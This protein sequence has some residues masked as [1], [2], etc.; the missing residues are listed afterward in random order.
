VSPPPPVRPVDV[1]A[2]GG[3]IAMRGEHAQPALDAEALVAA[4]PGLAAV[5]G[6]RARTV[7]NV[8]GPHLTPAMALEVALAA[9]DAAR[10]G[11]GVVVTHGTDTLEETAL[12]CDLVADAQ[13][14]I[15][16]TGA[17]RPASAPGADG[18]ANL[19]DAVAAAGAA[20]TTG[21]GAL[22]CF[23]GEL[24]A[25]RFARKVDS[26]GPAAFASPRSGPVGRVAE[27]RAALWALPVRGP[28]LD[29]PALD[30]RVEVV[31]AYMGADGTLLRA[32]AA[33]ADGIVVE[34]LGAGHTPPG[35]F[36]AL[37]EVA[38]RLPLVAVVRPPRGAILH[39]TYG[40]EGCERDLRAT[41]AIPAGLLS[42][43]GARMKLLA[44]LGAGLA[45][46]ELRA[47]FA[48]DD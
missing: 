34:V 27:G 41:A 10:A 29:P 13:A 35:L 16:V 38:E 40:F 3:T 8:P 1:L 47:A 22:V 4:V 45:D 32:A 20:A 7:A 15:V 19:L 48:L 31:P 30:G 12:L 44:C 24:H 6:L 37:A 25:A 28:A 2:V 43:P 23:G 46:A 42:A 5:D 9:R 18:P 21:A 17:M 36:A 11:R 33:S 26:T 39:A 14:P